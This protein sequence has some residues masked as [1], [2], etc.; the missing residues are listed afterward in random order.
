M[1]L[2]SYSNSSIKGTEIFL[3]L[4][5]IILLYDRPF[6][7]VCKKLNFENFSTFSNTFSTL[8]LVSVFN[9]YVVLYGDTDS[10]SVN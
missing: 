6:L 3:A 2:L 9:D 10:Y 7:Y 8:I 5:Y 4:F 1:I